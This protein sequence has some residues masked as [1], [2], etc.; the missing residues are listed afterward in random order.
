MNAEIIKNANRNR[1]AEKD[2]GPHAKSS[3]NE[4]LGQSGP[5]VLI[6]SRK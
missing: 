4:S 2:N 6:R 5:Q 1:V 3:M